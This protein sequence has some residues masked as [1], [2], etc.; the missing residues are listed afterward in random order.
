M[1]YRL[2]HLHAK[3]LV[4][5]CRSM[6]LAANSTADLWKSFM[7]F[8]NDIPER[9]GD[10]LYAL[11][12]Y[13]PGYFN[14]FDPARSF[15]KWAAV[16]VKHAVALPA[17]MQTFLLP[18]GLYAVFSYKGRAGSPEPFRYIFQEWLPAS[19]Y[20]LDDRPHFELLG[21]AYNNQNDDSEEELWIP[22]REKE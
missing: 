21:K 22:V 12:V 8:R 20:R 1:N 14:H 17:G 3:T 5:K 18:A 9:V 19:A 4:G 16:E 15:E 10:D 11:Q 7:P 6:S 13:P 2:A